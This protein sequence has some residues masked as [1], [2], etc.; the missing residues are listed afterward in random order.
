M[1]ARDVMSR[2][3]IS[4]GS[5]AK[6]ADAIGLML[7]F[8]FSGL[9]I[10]DARGQLVGMLTEGDLLRRAEL[11]T[12]R[13]RPR[14]IEA[15]LVPGR[16]ATD[17]VHAHG[18]TVSDVMTRSPV[19]VEET[20]SLNEV[21]GL[22]EGHH[23]KR[24]PVMRGEAIVGMITRAD[25]LRALAGACATEPLRMDDAALRGTI[26]ANLRSQEWAP[27]TAIRV[28]VANGVVDLRGTI[29]DDRFRDAIR[30]C[31]E[32][33][34]G[35]AAVRDHLVFVEPLSGAYVDPDEDAAVAGTAASSGGRKS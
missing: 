28:E 3:A 5:T 24:V 6:I 22:M 12:D 31:V 35:V 11:G 7:K 14:W 1:L 20:A 27:R 30:V 21:V 26:E 25:L 13:H 8:H 15:F 29:F 32:N 19:T 2:P 16:A 18:R 23:I 4:I 17:Y 34:P 33:T 9:P 10:T